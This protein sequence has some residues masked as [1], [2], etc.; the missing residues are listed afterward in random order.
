MRSRQKLT[1]TQGSI[2][3]API[4]EEEIIDGLMRTQRREMIPEKAPQRTESDS[5]KKK[6]NQRKK[7]FKEGK[8]SSEGPL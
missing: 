4:P 1:H 8:K 7:D 5:K 3:L 6:R 2:K